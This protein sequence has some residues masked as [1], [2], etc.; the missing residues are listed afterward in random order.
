MVTNHAT[1]KSGGIRH[2]VVACLLGMTVAGA[3]AGAQSATLPRVRNVFT[4]RP[5]AEGPV[6]RFAPIRVGPQGHVVFLSDT[7]AP[8][9][10]V[11][12]DSAGKV[13]ARL[14]PTGT[15]PGEVRAPWPITVTDAGVVVF[16]PITRRIAEWDFAGRLKRENTFLISLLLVDQVGNDLVGA[17]SA[18]NRWAPTA[19]S[20]SGDIRALSLPTDSFI[21]AQFGDFFTRT[22]NRI[23]PVVGIWDEGFLVGDPNTYRIGLYRWD[24]TLVRVLSRDL[25]VVHPTPTQLDEAVRST[26]DARKIGGL[27]MDSADIART[28]DGFSRQVVPPFLPGST[29]RMDAHHRLWIVGIEGDS[30]YADLFTAERFI[31]RLHLPCREFRGAWNISVDW[32]AMACAPARPDS[33]GAAIIKLFRIVEPK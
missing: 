16:D 31:G 30:A 10:V 9:R 2:G 14:A 25:P 13:I 18:N 12:T 8:K 4:T 15:G 27:S 22:T 29:F 20:W 26:R 5:G 19:M 24:N 23:P 28:R 33:D 6:S 32:L 3:N 21:T 17:F 11:L 1:P 7:L